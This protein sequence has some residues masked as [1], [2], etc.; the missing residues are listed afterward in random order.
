[1]NGNNDTNDR[2]KLMESTRAYKTKRALPGCSVRKEACVNELRHLVAVVV[3]LT[4]R[5][6]NKEE[7]DLAYTN[8]EI[9][10]ETASKYVR[11]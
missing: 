3:S 9:A 7:L 10:Y 6:S 1:M 8:L 5:D 11:N 2:V 4:I